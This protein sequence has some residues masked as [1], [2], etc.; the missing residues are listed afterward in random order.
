MVTMDFRKG[1]TIAASPAE[2]GDLPDGL[3]RTVKSLLCTILIKKLCGARAAH[4]LE[5]QVFMFAPQR[6][7]Y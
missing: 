4:W 6:Q 7:M 3:G 2:P 1:Q 5:K